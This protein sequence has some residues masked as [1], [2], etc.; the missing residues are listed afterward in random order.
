M[1]GPTKMTEHEADQDSTYTAAPVGWDDEAVLAA[2]G[3]NPEEMRKLLREA[4]QPLPT[5]T[6]IYQWYSRRKISGIWR[7]RVVYAL[8]RTQRIKLGELFRLERSLGSAE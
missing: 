1:Q 3:K 8:L 4:K 2:A 7:P 5:P 6:A